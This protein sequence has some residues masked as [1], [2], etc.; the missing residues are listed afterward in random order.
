[1]CVRLLQ[2]LEN[3]DLLPVASS[4]GFAAK[5]LLAGCQFY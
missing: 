1:V 5:S 2:P 4:E 3:Q